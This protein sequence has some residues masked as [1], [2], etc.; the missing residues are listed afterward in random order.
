MPIYE[1]LTTQGA[2][3]EEKRQRLAEEI[4]RIHTEETGSPADFVH[5]MFPELAPGYAF[6]AGRCAT[7]SVIR[8]QIRA[9]RP[10]EVRHAIIKRVFDFYAELTGAPIMSI[11]VAVMDLPAQWVM[12]AGRILPEPTPE[13]EAAWFE[14]VSPSKT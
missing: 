5:V 1:V 8:G 12:E 9:G 14:A 7:P 4:T 11:M 10:P 2:L 13:Q 6:R 3:D